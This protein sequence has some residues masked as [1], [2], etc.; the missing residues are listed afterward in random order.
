[1]TL[2][3]S[4]GLQF[5]GIS[6]TDWMQGI[7]SVIAIIGAI[8]GFFVLYRDSK[9]KQSQIDTLTKIAEET[10]KQTSQLISQVNV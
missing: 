4:N 7:G 1:M 3:I 2:E 8:V 9:E 10:E 6:I 5:G